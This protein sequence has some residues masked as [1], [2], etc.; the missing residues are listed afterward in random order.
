MLRPSD[1]S[2]CPPG[3][4]SSGR[5]GLQRRHYAGID[6]RIDRTACMPAM[7]NSNG[8]ALR[9]ERRGEAFELALEVGIG[10]GETLSVHERTNDR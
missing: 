1:C 5:V 10:C 6:R 2:A 8:I 7:A 3:G 9:M 4:K